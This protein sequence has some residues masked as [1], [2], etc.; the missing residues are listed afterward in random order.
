MSLSLIWMSHVTFM[1]Q[2][3]SRLWID[4]SY[5]RLYVFSHIYMRRRKDVLAHLWMSKSVRVRLLSYIYERRR[6]DVLAHFYK[7]D[8]THSYERQRQDS[9]INV[10]WLIHMRDRDMIHS[11]WKKTYSHTFTMTQS[12]ARL[13]SFIWETKKWLIRTCDMTH[14]YERLV[15]V[16]WLIHMRDREMTHS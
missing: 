9:F 6:K 2:S 13:D 12:Y 15:H 14:S 5:E 4:K 8:M 16:T 7:W 1:K 3:M 11:I 10:T